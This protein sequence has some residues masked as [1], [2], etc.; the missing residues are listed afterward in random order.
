M[1]HAARLA[2]FVGVVLTTVAIAA[3]SPDKKL[4]VFGWNTQEPPVIS[5]N[6]DRYEASPLQGMVIGVTIPRYEKPTQRAKTNRFGWLA[7]GVA[8]TEDDVAESIRVLRS[9]RASD[10]TTEFFLRLNI[11]PGNVDWFDD[12]AWAA[13]VANNWRLAGKI[14]REGRLRGIL[15]DTEVYAPSTNLWTFQWAGQDGK[16]SW[17]ECLDMAFERGRQNVQAL[18]SQIEDVDILTTFMHGSVLESLGRRG[19]PERLEH[20]AYGL[21]PAY[22]DG[23]LSAKAPRTQIHDGWEGSYRYKTRGQF[24]EAIEIM[25]EAANLSLVPRTYLANLRPGFGIWT[26][27]AKGRWDPNTPYYAPSELQAAM[28][29][30]F[31]F[32]DRYVWLYHQCIHPWKEPMFPEAYWQ[33]MRQVVKPYASAPASRTLDETAR[34]PRS[35]TP[36]ASQRE[37]VLIGYWP[38]QTSL[39]NTRDGRPALSASGDASAAFARVGIGTHQALVPDEGPVSYAVPRASW[40]EGLPATCTI[41]LAIFPTG[42][43]AHRVI[44]SGRL[45]Q[46]HRFELTGRTDRHGHQLKVR[47]IESSPTF[48]AWEAETGPYLR[49][50]PYLVTLRFD[51]GR[52]AGLFVNKH[53]AIYELLP[54][55]PREDSTGD[56]DTLALDRVI[57]PVGHLKVW[58]GTLS[59]RQIQESVKVLPD[60]RAEPSP[61]IV[62][63]ELAGDGIVVTDR[64]HVPTSTNFSL[65]SLTGAVSARLAARVRRGAVL[66]LHPAREAFLTSGPQPATAE[67][68]AVDHVAYVIEF[69]ARSMPPEGGA[70]G[71]FGRGDGSNGNTSFGIYFDHEGRALANVK[72]TSNW[73]RSFASPAGHIR[74]DRWHTLTFALDRA[75]GTL[76][77][78]LDGQVIA[79]QPI[80]VDIANTPQSLHHRQMPLQ[81]GYVRVQPYAFAPYEP[82]SE[83]CR[84]DGLIRAFRIER[85]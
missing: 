10:K 19:K 47:V 24:E 71:L 14:V 54:A 35:Q 42:E 45:G 48:R 9:R 81:I 18:N 78:E 13:R 34:A 5:G 46:D 27:D 2:S 7:W 4:I 61:G 20:H 21:L 15:F 17:A 38:L 55:E 30:A 25:R 84:F 43:S 28:G 80:A 32:A 74:A 40:P 83:H 8:M 85:R 26:D 56:R 52:F 41:S 3:E 49:H 1:A 73:T 69:R 58:K 72:S 29:Y 66:D 77:L 23:M 37:P 82:E 44:L 33:A 65:T 75:D 12:E 22:F 64:W 51:R 62:D 57:Y 59:H 76:T 39:K 67:S 60:W 16:R 50:H 36:S 6:M 31:E 63:L 70:Y 68:Y 79:R 53:R 11:T